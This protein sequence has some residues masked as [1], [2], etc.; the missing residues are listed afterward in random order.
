MTQNAAPATVGYVSSQS[1]P[2]CAQNPVSDKILYGQPVCA[3]CYSSLMWRRLGAYVLDSLIMIIPSFIIR[4]TLGIMAGAM[5]SGLFV[6]I[7]LNMISNAIVSVIFAMKDGINGA[8]PGKMILELQ[9]IDNSTG[10][11]IGFQQSLK[12]NSFILLNIIPFI[13][14]LP[15]IVLVL[16][17]AFSLGKGY[18]L[19]DAFANTKVIWKRYAGAP[20][21]RA[22][23]GPGFEVAPLAT[24]VAS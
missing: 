4:F 22:G 16:V 24:P 12:R 13:G 10:Q 19:G 2:I 21:F 20:V 8:S 7:V 23:Q 15:A 18:R 5:H 9:V 11:P 6:S 17:I 14:W 3:S 1:C